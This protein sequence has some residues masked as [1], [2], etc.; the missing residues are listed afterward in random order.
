MHK[1][2]III[3]LS[4]FTGSVA[5]QAQQSF[6]LDE[7]VKYAIEHHSSTHINAIN[8]ADA[9]QNM[10]ELRSIG[11]PKLTG[12]L[13]YNYFI[14]TPSVPVG[15][16]LTPAIKGILIG[17][18]VAADYPQ[19][20]ELQ[21]QQGGQLSFQQKNNFAASADFSWLAF[22]GSYL[23]A[24]E[25][26]KTYR[27]LVSLQSEVSPITLRNTIT[28]AYYAV[29]IVEKNKEILEK[30]I[31]N[32]NLLRND[33]AAINKQGLNEK[34]DVDRVDLSL[35]TLQS[36]TSNLTRSIELMK[37]LLKFQ[38]QYT[39]D[40]PIV[41]SDSFDELFNNAENHPELA[42]AELS[43]NDKPEYLVLQKANELAALD[44]KRYRMA[45]WPSLIIISSFQRSFQSDNIFKKGGTWLPTSLVGAQL[46]I[47]IFDGWEKDA[48][49][50][51]A[52]LKVEKNNVDIEN[53]Q[54]AINLSLTNS[55]NQYLIA[56]ETVDTRS[57]ALKLADEIFRV[58][59]IKYKEGIGSSFEVKQAETDVYAAQ[60]NLLQAQ[61]ELIKAF[62]EIQKALGKYTF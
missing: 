47:P 8:M 62:S 27:E 40:Q 58:S 32:L 28:D 29:L 13:G 43:F 53:Y 16:F 57:K 14:E 35:A 60:N 48:K 46:N 26:A 5:L 23:V 52:K 30:N 22:D 56:R 45:Y 12:K 36:T 34:L 17:T 19:I 2:F 49:M 18:G 10:R 9:E 44:I 51:R 42:A 6:T 59:N 50:Q 24:L 21:A 54:R 31:A 11:L 20:N 61:Y 25:A 15:D 1:L 37:D 4:L 39:P 3:L 38:M 55:R 41:L 7:A 33:V